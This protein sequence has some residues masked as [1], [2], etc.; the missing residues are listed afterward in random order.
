MTPNMFSSSSSIQTSAPAP[1]VRQ[2][3]GVNNI[4]P[5]H[6]PSTH[7]P[8]NVVTKTGANTALQ[9]TLVASATAPSVEKN[10]EIPQDAS[11]K[12]RPTDRRSQVGNL[13][14]EWKWD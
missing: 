9:A 11:K 7:H 4:K 3:P 1:I 6:A 5:R 14:L 10:P 8:A 12:D 2:A 13:L